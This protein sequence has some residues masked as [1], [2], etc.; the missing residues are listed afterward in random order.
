ML[1]FPEASCTFLHPRY[2]A[3]CQAAGLVPIVEPEVLC[4]GEHSLERCMKVG[5]SL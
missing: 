5:H 1:I 3:T 2:A 4:D